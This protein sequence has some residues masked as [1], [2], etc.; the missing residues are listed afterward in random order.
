M[1]SLPI[2]WES[3][4]SD[5]LKPICITAPAP[6]CWGRFGFDKQAEYIKE[7]LKRVPS[8]FLRRKLAHQV[9]ARFN[10]ETAKNPIRSA[11]IHL[12]ETVKRIDEIVTR[13]PL[14]ARELSDRKRRK[15]KAKQ[16]ATICNQIGLLDAL[17][18]IDS[19]KAADL[20]IHYYG[21]M[22]A[23]TQGQGVTPPQ[24]ALYESYK[25]P[26]SQTKLS[27]VEVADRL[28]IAI[29]R[30]TCA[31]WWERKLQRLRDTTLEHLNI[32]MGLVKKGV[33]AYA[34]KQAI[35]EFKHSKK[36]QREWLDSMQIESECGQVADL[37]AVFEKTLSNPDLRRIEMIVRARG[38][39]EYAESQGMVSAM[40]TI[41]APS[42]YHAASHKYNNA[43]PKETQAYLVGQWAKMRATLAKEGVPV[44]GVRVT[45]PHH[46]ATPHWHLLLFMRPDDKALTDSVL[47]RFAL[48]DDGDEAGAS[49]RRFRIENIDPK[50]GCAVS[51]L[52]KY[53][54]KNINAKHLDGEKDHETGDNFTAENGVIHNVG[55]WAS[56]WRIRQFQ[57]IGGPSIGLWREFRRVKPE[58]AARLPEA[59]AQAYAHANNSRFAA[60]IESLGG[61]FARRKD[62]PFQLSTVI[63][64]ENQY[65][66]R[67]KRLE[68]ISFTNN[69]TNYL[70]STRATRW[71]LKKRDSASPWS[72][73]NNCNSPQ[74]DWQIS[75]G[76]KLNPITFI[77]PEVRKPILSGATY[78]E[79]DE[80]RHTITEY[81][82][83][84]GSLVSE[85]YD[86][87]ELIQ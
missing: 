19:D 45:E 83:K 78:T 35:Q 4:G 37:K 72:T 55:A 87:K 39:K 80:A 1:R 15:D 41:T 18:N 81:Q 76:E 7:Q 57:F 27:K 86:Y 66:D 44:F 85:S 53:I 25:N 70:I 71:A 65:G 62:R 21:E 82:V 33:S 64:G 60:F 46:D 14:T 11:N 16:L 22:A 54:S 48:Q 58:S 74:N 13:S 50:I 38:F 59:A 9:A 30:M 10:S 67:T 40:Y 12:R 69:K 61:A 34:S 43:T 63:T 28:G 84:S 51:Y 68:G 42:K 31:Q 20:L 8:N 75:H 17:Y 47:R 36:Q 32:S 77:P 79:I 23:F 73:E 2:A 26:N 49:E 6:H 5:K 3:N 29:N 56:R 24:W 52:I